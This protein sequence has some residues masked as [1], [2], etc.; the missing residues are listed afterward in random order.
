MMRSILY[1]SVDN[2]LEVHRRVIEGFGGDFGLRD[3]G[4]LESAVALP[5][6]SFGGT[7][8]HLSL[9]AKA[10]A[11]HF[12]LCSNQA[13]VDGN[14]RVAVAASELFLLLNGLELQAEDSA[15]EELTFGVAQG[16]VAKEQ[17]LAFFAENTKK[18]GPS[19]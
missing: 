4:L 12:H 9:P 14:K 13:F 18:A 5:Y 17:V 8:L 7:E 2:V 1:L 15:L 19:V 3:R 11:Y 16:S 10:G 6:A